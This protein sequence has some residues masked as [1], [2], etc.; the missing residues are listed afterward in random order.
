MVKYVLDVVTPTLPKNSTLPLGMYLPR[1]SGTYELEFIHEG[2]AAQI[3]IFDDLQGGPYVQLIWRRGD[4]RPARVP[5]RSIEDR[6]M[7][8]TTSEE[9]QMTI[10]SYIEG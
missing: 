5:I 1:Y 4:T 3:Q 9:G 8:T 7:V 10:R 6:I 2:C